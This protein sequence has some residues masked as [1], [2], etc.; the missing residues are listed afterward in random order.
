LHNGRS[1][2]FFCTGPTM[3][4]FMSPFSPIPERISD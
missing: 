3:I 2:P 4:S 1:F